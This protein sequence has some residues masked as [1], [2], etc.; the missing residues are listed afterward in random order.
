MISNVANED[1]GCVGIGAG[2]VTDITITHNEINDVPY[3]GISMGWGWTKTSNVMKNNKIIGNKILHYGRQLYDVAAIYTLSAQPGS[4]ISDNYIDSI[5]KAPYAHLPY[6]WFYLYTDEGSSYFTIKNNWCPSEK[7]LQNANGPG[8]NWS[9]NGP[10]V[11][12]NVKLNAG[13]RAPYQYLW[14]HRANREWPINKEKPIIVELIA[15]KEL[16]TVQLRKI[17]VQQKVNPTAVYQWQNHYVI[18]DRVADPGQLKQKLTANFPTVQV[19]IYDDLFYEFNR[20]YCNDK[21]SAKEWQHIILTADLVD[22]KKLQ[23]EYLD[24]HATQF[25][26][27]PELSRGFCNADFQQ[28]LLFKNGQQ[29]MLVISIPKGESLDQLNPRTTAN[30]PRVDEWNQMMKK[31]QKGI[32]GTKN[33]EVWVFLKQL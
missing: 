15:T 5:Y 1:W 22:D 27:W 14:K 18:F 7:F 17:L 33:G 8:N 23:Q 32:A 30:N 10:Q 3:T 6:H 19:K 24:H 25:E 31:Y 12:N 26:K 11:N 29:L 28:L 2:Y 16:D 9:N 13:I 4:V 21:N 20:S